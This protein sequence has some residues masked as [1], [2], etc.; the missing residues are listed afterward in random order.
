M[1]LGWQHRI[2]SLHK[3]LGGCVVNRSDVEEQLAIFV[4]L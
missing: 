3:H 1:H 4:V 2:L